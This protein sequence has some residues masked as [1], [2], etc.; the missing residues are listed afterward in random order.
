MWMRCCCFAPRADL[1]CNLTG[2][3]TEAAIN[4]LF[5]LSRPV[6]GACGIDAI[7]RADAKSSK[8]PSAI[9]H[10]PLTLRDHL[11]LLPQMGYTVDY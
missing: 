10:H 9:L 8:G 1:S 3:R 5:L 7:A 2:K 6:V 11:E 4:R